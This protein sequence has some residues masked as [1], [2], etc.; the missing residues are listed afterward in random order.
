MNEQSIGTMAAV[1][2]QAGIAYEIIESDTYQMSQ[3]KW[4]VQ[5]SDL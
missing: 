5:F 4:S 1:I 2:K 3:L